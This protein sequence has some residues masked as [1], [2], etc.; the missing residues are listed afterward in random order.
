MYT[1]GL[2]C[3]HICE[4]R[5]HLQYSNLERNVTTSVHHDCN[6][7]CCKHPEQFAYYLMSKTG[8]FFEKMGPQSVLFKHKFESTVIHVFITWLVSK[9]DLSSQH[10]V[11]TPPT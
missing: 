3:A 10:G 5:Y 11:A 4:I 8:S 6:G 7:I 9:W 1:Y 2:S